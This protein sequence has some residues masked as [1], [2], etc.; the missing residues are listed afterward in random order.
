MQSS[1]KENYLIS[2]FFAF[3]LIHSTSNYAA[4]I[5][6]QIFLH[7]DAGHD[8]WISVL[9]MGISLHVIIWM[10]YKM[11]D[12]PAK[13]V[14][15]L[16]RLIFGKLFGNA[17]SLLM[18]GYFFMLALS[19]LRTYIDVLQ[20]WIFPT[21]RTWE[22]SFIFLCIMYY[23]VSGGFRVLT[24]FAF[25]AV[26]ISTLI[27]TLTYFP[28]TYGNLTYL[29][30]VWNH[31]LP[32]LLKSSKAASGLFIGFE[33]L[34]VFFPF[35]RPSDKHA[36][37]AHL[38]LLFTTLQFAFIT[39]STLLYFSQGLL[40][41]TLYPLLVETKIIQFPFAERFEFLFI[42]GWFIIIIP[43]I[44]ISI[45]SCTRIMK[46]VMNLKPSTSLPCILIT[47]FIAV[48]LF[49][50]RIKVDELSRF[51]TGL[52]FYFLYGYIPLLFILFLIRS[53]LLRSIGSAK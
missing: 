53:K 48:L 20:V 33:S 49:N 23:I 17:V 52:G 4:A 5:S 13:D 36:K 27:F 51:V 26:L 10:T 32:D 6:S 22:L 47:F 9:F 41:Q 34:L 50:D 25:F 19:E 16:H 38:G 30:P 7:K 31:S 18:I 40:Q 8:A 39:V 2:G 21:V 14:M 28:T 3:F 42:F 37:W 45:W 24:G 15:E 1:I 35:I 11:L 46:K 29:L 44:C 43:S 12:N